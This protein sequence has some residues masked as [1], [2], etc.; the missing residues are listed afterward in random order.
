MRENKE[1]EKAASNKEI[2]FELL[3]ILFYCL[4]KFR[5]KQKG[6]KCDICTSF[7]RNF[8]ALY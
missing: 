6:D 3:L 1:A 7:T 2:E 5:Q 4:F 8:L